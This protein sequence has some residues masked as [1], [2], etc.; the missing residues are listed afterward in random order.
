MPGNIQYNCIIIDDDDVD[1]LTVHAFVREHPS[2]LVRGTYGSVAE[3]L[4]GIGQ[5]SPD[6]IFSDIDMPGTNGLEF[7]RKMIQVPVCVFVTAYAEYA[8]DSYEVAAFDFLVKPLRQDRFNSTIE[9]ILTYFE[10]RQKARLYDYGLNTATDAIFIKEGHQYIKLALRDILYLEAL[11]DYTLV[12]TPQKRFCVLSPIGN[13]LK[14]NNFS[15]FVRIH[16]SFAVQK[17]LIDT[18]TAQHVTIHNITLPVG[19]GYAQN[20]GFIK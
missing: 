18:L 8:L 15:G 11:K 14:E 19:R 2:L 3:A 20:L 5:Q 7:R 1:R 13:L 9:R 4:R 12:I 16:R 6:I 17:Q 10:F